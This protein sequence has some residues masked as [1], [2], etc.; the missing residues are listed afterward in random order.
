MESSHYHYSHCCTCGGERD[1]THKTDVGVDV[2]KLTFFVYILLFVVGFG[3]IYYNMQI[4]QNL[5]PALSTPL[6]GILA[7][8]I[9]MYCAKQ[10]A[11][12][13]RKLYE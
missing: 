9:Y 3:H 11:D 10:W 2:S 5:Y 7:G 1:A 4:I 13:W 12:I 6:L 8:I